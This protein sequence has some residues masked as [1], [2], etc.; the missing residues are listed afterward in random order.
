MSGLE[1]NIRELISPVC[2]AENIFLHSV[3]VSGGGKNMNIRVV[4]DTEMGITLGECQA[5]SGKISDL[6]YR[7]DVIKGTYRLE[8]SS[9]GVNKP[10]EHDFEYQRNIGKQLSV[11]YVDDNG[12]QSITGE[13][14]DCNKKT[15]RLKSD[16]G[17]TKIARKAV[18][19]AKIKLKW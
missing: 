15:I 9:P 16:N 7:K 11:N 2:L 17:E 19:K 12:E 5:L 18:I 10:L 14:L 13:L 3:S 1:E 8:V 6:F 4:V